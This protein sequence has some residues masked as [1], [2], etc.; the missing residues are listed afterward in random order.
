MP[1][2]SGNF[3]ARLADG[4]IAI[5]ASGRHKGRL[6][7]QDVIAV[8]LEGRPLS[9]RVR[10]S[11]ETPLHLALY[12]ADPGVDAVFHV[13]SPHATLVS[14]TRGDALVLSGYEVLKAFPGIE[15]HEA[16][17][18]VPIFPNDQDVSR[19]AARVEAWRAGRTT[20]GYLIAGHGLYTWGASLDD[21][22]RHT[23]ALDFLFHCTLMRGA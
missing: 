21:A 4:N 19:L 1:A 16:E 14:M 20:W 9:P 22:V 15:T 7:Q 11:A 3:S 6:R 13:H 17:L 8:D 12:R 18:V 23:E 5:T 2:T 10:P